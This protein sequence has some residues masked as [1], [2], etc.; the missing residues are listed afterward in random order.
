MHTVCVF[1]GPSMYM[2]TRL[3]EGAQRAIG[4]AEKHRKHLPLTTAS[5]PWIK[6]T[7]SL[8]VSQMCLQSYSSGSV[9]LMSY[10]K[11]SKF[12]KS[13]IAKIPSLSALWKIDCV[14]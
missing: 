8:Q 12:S 10:S 4:V 1:S 3:V 5:G 2:V 11:F 6:T 14:K 9:E 7:P 13:K